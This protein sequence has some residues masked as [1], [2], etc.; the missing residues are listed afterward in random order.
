MA[1]RGTS[2]LPVGLVAVDGSFDAGDAVELVGPDGSRFADRRQPLPGA[3][4]GRGW[5]AGEACPRPCAATIWCWCER[6]RC[7]RA[8][9]FALAAPHAFLPRLDGEARN[10]ALGRDRRGARAAL[11]RGARRQRRRRGR[12]IRRDRRD[13]R[14]AHARPGSAR[15]PSP[16]GVLTIADLPDPIGA[17][18]RDFTL[19]NGIRVRKLRV[20]LGV[21]M[22]V[23]EARPNVAVDAAALCIKSGNACILRGSRLA[24]RTNS[25][26]VDIVRDSLEAA[27][28]PGRRRRRRR[29]RA[30]GARR[31]PRRSGDGRCRHPPRR[32][33]AEE[34]APARLAD[35]CAGGGRRELPRLRRR[36][37]RR[38]RRGRDRRQCED[39]APGRVQRGRDA[40]RAPRP[41]GAPR[42]DLRRAPCRR[43]RDPGGR[44][45][46]GDGVP[47]HA[48]GRPHRRLARRGDR[49]REPLWHRALRGDRHVRLRGRGAILRTR[50]TPPRST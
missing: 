28:H 16:A 37:R 15:R 17:V 39:A 27:R 35:P 48:D 1:E 10:A 7:S 36:L 46:V 2:L 12:R 29:R 33:G 18:L 9:P 13:R 32:R 40:A 21:V 49:A 38:C 14:P 8:R 31:A 47:R 34:A 26:L 44:G 43:G 4:A 5:P 42:R 45:G 11:G 25:V 41:A 23:F 19:E 30:R 6:D 3:R 24:A 22:V 50:S 20:P